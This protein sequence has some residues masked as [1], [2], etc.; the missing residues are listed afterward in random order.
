MENSW[1]LI[2]ANSYYDAEAN[3]VKYFT[4][5]LGI[6]LQIVNV[7]Y[8]FLFKQGNLPLLIIGPKVLQK[9]EISKFLVNEYLK[10]CQ[11][12][13]EQYFNLFDN[14]YQMLEIIDYFMWAAPSNILYQYKDQYTFFNAINK[15]YQCRFLIN[16]KKR[17]KQ[18][19]YLDN[20]NVNN[21]AKIHLTIIQHW[22]KMQHEQQQPVNVYYIFCFVV[23]K[24]IIFNIRY[25]QLYNQILKSELK[26]LLQ[27][28]TLRLEQE[29][30]LEPIQGIKD[31]VALYNQQLDKLLQIN[32]DL[33]PKRNSH[34][35]I[36]QF[37]SLSLFTYV[38]ISNDFK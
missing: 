16:Q 38:L 4:K 25:S 32:K 23:L 15:Y 28:M 18:L 37:I 13:Y 8:L 17:F 6:D 35:L 5:G 29:F 30:Q 11:Q 20:N 34:Q 3:L 33:K 1:K 14:C 7:E 10:N 22:I 12:N 31:S 21:K 19:K 9:G 36:L 2:T 26:D 27:Q 24:S